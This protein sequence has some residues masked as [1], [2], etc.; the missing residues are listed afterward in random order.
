MLCIK[1][2]RVGNY[3]LTFKY[4]YLSCNGGQWTKVTG[5]KAIAVG[6]GVF[7][8]QYEVL[9]GGLSDFGVFNN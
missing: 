7:D 8:A 5:V 6:R 2:K 4:A 1:G 3:F 9:P